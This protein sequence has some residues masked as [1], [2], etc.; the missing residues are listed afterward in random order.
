LWGCAI[1]VAAPRG[2][3]GSEVPACLLDGGG[4]CSNHSMHQRPFSF[5]PVGLIVPGGRETGCDVFL[6]SWRL[7]GWKSIVL[8]ET[9]IFLGADMTGSSLTYLS[10][11][12]VT[13]SCQWRGEW[14]AVGDASGLVISLIDVRRRWSNSGRE[15]IVGG[16]SVLLGHWHS[17]CSREVVVSSWC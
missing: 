2:D 4:H 14:W 1:S 17:C 9:I 13:S 6:W 16:G 8:L 7:R 15:C 10:R 3:K 12:A 11:P 5:F